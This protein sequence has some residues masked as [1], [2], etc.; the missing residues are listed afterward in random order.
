[1]GGNSSRS[2]RA[3][4]GRRAFCRCLAYLEAISYQLSAIS[5]QLSAIRYPLSSSISQPLSPPT[6]ML[7]AGDKAPAFSLK[8]G[9][10]DTVK[11]SDLQG[12]KV[13]LY[14]YPKD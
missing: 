13:V 7:K 1:M 4:M 11:L 2:Q 5:Y 9:E 3:G 14:F 6:A 12:K 10:G 8:T